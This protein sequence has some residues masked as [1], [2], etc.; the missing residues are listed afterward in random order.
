MCTP[1]KIYDRMLINREEESTRENIMEEQGRFRSGIEGAGREMSGEGGG[2]AVCSV[3]GLEE[4][5]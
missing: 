4:G 2:G 5:A 1:R 3:Y